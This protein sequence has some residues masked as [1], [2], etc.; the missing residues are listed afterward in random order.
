M[1]KTKVINVG[2][3]TLSR[4]GSR[5]VVLKPPLRDFSVPSHPLLPERV[6]VVFSRTRALELLKMPAKIAA[7]AP[8]LAAVK[9][10]R[11]AASRKYIAEKRAIARK[12]REIDSLLEL[13]QAKLQ[14]PEVYKGR[15]AITSTTCG[16]LWFGCTLLSAKQLAAIKA[17]L[18]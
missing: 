8:K 1:N 14:K 16:G 9:A 10:K 7:K 5:I 3:Y 12:Y 11:K 13:E 2:N 15:Y 17:L 4:V 18:K 6:E